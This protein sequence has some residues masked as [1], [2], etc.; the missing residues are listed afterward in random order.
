M[1]SSMNQS[2]K[3]DIIDMSITH[4]VEL[5]KGDTQSCIQVPESEDIVNESKKKMTMYKSQSN[6]EFLHDQRLE[7]MMIIIMSKQRGIDDSQM[8]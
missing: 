1:S 7:F 6:F 5:V 2:L 3:I 4:A 8:V